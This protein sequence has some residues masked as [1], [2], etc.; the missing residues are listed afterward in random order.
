MSF[1]ES[2]AVTLQSVV[3][4]RRRTLVRCAKMLRKWGLK[5]SIC[6]STKR[7]QFISMEKHVL[8]NCETIG[9]DRK[10]RSKKLGSFSETNP[11][12]A[13]CFWVFG[14]YITCLARWRNSIGVKMLRKLEAAYNRWTSGGRLP[15]RYRGVSSDSA[16]GRLTC[17]VGRPTHNGELAAKEFRSYGPRPKEA[18]AGGVPGEIFALYL[19]GDALI[20]NLFAQGEH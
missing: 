13:S 1:H 20:V 15:R 10:D 8:S 5:G 9:S 16:F 4:L 12:L 6:D 17:A 7:T 11:I 3:R 14:R 19:F 18:S 2:L